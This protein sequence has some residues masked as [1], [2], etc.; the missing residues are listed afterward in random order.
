MADEPKDVLIEAAVSAFRERNAFGRIL[1]A[2][3]WWDLAPEDR[4]ALF[5]RQLESRLLERA[6]DP[7]GLSSTAR[8]VLERL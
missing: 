4:E 6:I 5:G 8:A 1:P 7:D 2:S 3:A